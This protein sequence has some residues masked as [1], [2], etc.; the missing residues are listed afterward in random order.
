M[1]PPARLLWFLPILLHASA[2]G[3]GAGLLLT[4]LT[5]KY[6]DMMFFMPFFSQLWMY[7]TPII[8][9]A[10]NVPE[11]WRW[12]ILYNPMSWAIEGTR[13]ALAGRG[14]FALDQV[15][16]GGALAVAVLGLGLMAFNRVQRTFIDVI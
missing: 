12:V 5:I 7:A 13:W 16:V 2:M 10:S 1:P 4:S 11:S 6:K 15:A 9:P 8:Y 14:T 3:L